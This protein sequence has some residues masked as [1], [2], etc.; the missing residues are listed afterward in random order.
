MELLDYVREVTGDTTDTLEK[1]ANMVEKLLVPMEEGL[2]EHKRA[3]L[4][5]L[6]ILNGTV[7][8]DDISWR[9]HEILL[10]HR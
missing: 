1:S 8:D 7:R 5:K 4:P 2:N 6:A 9:T 10:E 3:Q